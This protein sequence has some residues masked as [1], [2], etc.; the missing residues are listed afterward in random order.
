MANLRYKTRGNTNPKG[1]PKV[2]FC[3]HPED[4]VKCFQNISNEILDKQDCAIWFADGHIERDEEFYEDLKQMQLFVMPVTTNLLCTE[5]EALTVEFGFA[6]KNHIP[7]LPLMQESG[8]EKLFNEKCGDLQFLDKYNTDTTAIGYDEKLQKYLEAVLISDKLAEKIR[9]A[10][11]AYV[12]LS[13]RKK[14]RKH[15][16]ELMRL[17]HQNDFCRDIAIWYDEFL[18]PGENFNDSIKEALQK[19]GLFVL[20]VTPNLVNEENYI[21]TTEYPMAKRDGKLILPAEIVP[22]DK[23]QLRA[24]YK[25]IPTCANAHNAIEL[26]DA[27][28]DAVTKMAVKENDSSPE[29]NYFIGLA[30][31]SGIDVEVDYDR[32]LSLI[33]SAADKGL[34]EAQKKL[35]SMYSE[36]IGVPRDFDTAIVWQKKVVE[37][38][39]VRVV[40]C[41][42]AKEHSAEIFG[43][44]DILMSCI[45]LDEALKLYTNLLEICDEYFL[46]FESQHFVRLRTVI[47]ISIGDIYKSNGK[48][49]LAKKYY[50]EAFSLYETHKEEANMSTN[51][52]YLVAGR[53]GEISALNSDYADAEKYFLLAIE[54]CEKMSEAATD[55]NKHLMLSIAYNNL[56]LVYEHKLDIDSAIEFTSK[57]ISEAKC[58]SEILGD[59]FSYPYYFAAVMHLSNIYSRA[60]QYEKAMV[61]LV[62]LK[63]VSED[64]Y[65][66]TGRPDVKRNLARLY[67]N[68]AQCVKGDFDKAHEEYARS[69]DLYW[70][71]VCETNSYADKVNLIKVCCAIGYLF[72]TEKAKTTLALKY[73]EKAFSLIENI[74]I[75]NFAA[76]DL[77]SIEDY[78]SGM[79]AL[80][81]LRG[82]YSKARIKYLDAISCAK[83]REKGGM[84]EL[85][86]LAYE[87][88]KV[89]ETYYMEFEH[90][91]SIEYYQIAVNI[92]RSIEGYERADKVMGLLSACCDWLGII[93]KIKKN[94]DD[95]EKFYKMSHEMNL[96][97]V[98]SNPN[99]NNRR[100]IAMY[101]IKIGE[102]KELR[103]DISDAVEHYKKCVQMCIELSQ[104][105][106]YRQCY[107]DLAAA[108]HQLAR[109]E[110]KKANLQKAYSIISQLVAQFPDVS[111]YSELEKIYKKDLDECE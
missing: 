111:L 67:K 68:I 17:I 107:A 16:Q 58:A 12:F 69:F 45:K 91:N 43:L 38:L 37:N 8:L 21:M 99:Y 86:K 82:E 70:E 30:Y 34:V 31:L 48:I 9:S 23:E 10:F 100:N 98:E 61:P 2:Y 3:C 87:H 7:V 62:G 109:V 6:V 108:Y 33:K 40:D 46:R 90:D 76:D 85:Y 56:A 84:E 65:S 41:D 47:L 110:D 83:K 79:G 1:K 44:A 13:Y 80:Y 49:L 29:H 52:M 81:H 24:A 18:T 71:L 63:D 51:I 42:S 93:H 60:N 73:Y 28:L 54:L 14:D 19:S 88:M 57:A 75:E 72:N 39:R 20:T 15:A 102:I 27:L 59:V 77:I 53:I 92:C 32:A 66:R 64:V 4:F 36:G 101:N 94:I 74:G 11:D 22:T 5:N 89:A 105:F 97:L 103:G 35:V 106:S 50:E 95:A 104:A 96:K 55:F 25:G 26:S 78:F